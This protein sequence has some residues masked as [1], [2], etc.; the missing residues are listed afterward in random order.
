MSMP[1]RI[2]RG[3]IYPK[4]SYTGLGAC[5][6]A[7]ETQAK[8]LQDAFISSSAQLSTGTI[9]IELLRVASVSLDGNGNP[10]VPRS[11]ALATPVS[12]N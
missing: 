11:F 12:L 8:L 6:W 9:I 7:T 3:A 1:L 10:S 5:L 2:L 4:S